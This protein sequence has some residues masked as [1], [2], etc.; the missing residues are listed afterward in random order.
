MGWD[1]TGWE[2]DV[3]VS[4][5]DFWSEASGFD[6]PYSPGYQLTRWCQRKHSPLKMGRRSF[7]S[8]AGHVW[9]WV[10]MRTHGGVH[11]SM[12]E[13]GMVPSGRDGSMM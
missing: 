4:I 1:G 6:S 13:V 3:A 12:V 2:Y 9:V 8:A 5:P 11:V 7:E 10:R